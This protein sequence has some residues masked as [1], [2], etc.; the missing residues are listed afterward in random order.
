[1]A[2]APS[3]LS[4]AISGSYRID[5]ELGRGGMAVVFL[6]RDLKHDRNVALKVIRPDVSYP[7]IADRFAREIRLA[8]RLQ[9]PHILPVLDSG[10][11]A[12][13]LWYTM[14]YVEGE[15]L[16]DRL[17]REKQLPIAEAL[18]VTRE[19]AQALE[20]AHQHSVIHRDIKPENILLTKDGSVLVADF[21]IARAIAGP[22]NTT[23]TAGGS[24]Q[25]TETGVS[26]GTP[27]YMSPEQ[28]LGVPADARS[29]IYSLAAVLSELVTGRMVG[30]GGGEGFEHFLKQLSDTAP[31]IRVLR[32]EVSDAVESAV[33]R[34]L[35]PDPMQRFP[36]M[37]AFARALD[38]PG[39]SPPTSSPGVRRAML[40]LVT[41]GV[42][43]SAGLLF[44]A[45]SRGQGESSSAVKTMVVLPFVDVS[46]D[47]AEAYFAQGMADELT[48]TLVQLS[49]VRLAGQSAVARLKP[50]EMNARDAG[51]R[52]NVES[53]LEGTVRR[54]GPRLRVTAQL[55]NAADGI[56]LW[57]ERYDR[58][59]KDVFQVQDEITRAIAT[60][61]RATLGQPLS[62]ATADLEAYDLYL[63]GRYY[64]S[65]RGSEGLNKAIDFFGRAVQS[66]SS[67]ARAHAGLSMAYA[68]LPIFESIDPDSAMMLAE[69]SAAHALALDSSLAEAHLAL[70]YTL[71]NRWRFVEAEREFRAALALAPNDPGVH[72][73]YG[74]LLYAIGRPE[75]SVNELIRAREL[76]PF[77][78][79]IG[80]DAGIA[81]YAARRFDDARRE[82]ERSYQLDSTKSD[83]WLVVAWTQLALGFPDSAIASLERS[84]RFR[85]AFDIRPYL[86]VA[87]RRLGET[88]KADSVAALLRRDYARG[89]AFAF[90]VAI[91]AA[92]AGDRSTAIRAIEQTLE[93]KSLL[94]TEVSL[95][96][97]PLL[98]PIRD[99]PRFERMLATVG[100]QACRPTPPP[101]GTSA[102]RSPG[103]PPG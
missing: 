96:C 33:R 70:A 79:T 60:A 76:D 91:A 45:L 9:H 62:T 54:S 90:D 46:G 52:L 44:K 71:K 53:V 78:S 95:P 10:E 39:G 14:P 93:D 84:Q 19:A 13:Q 75:E 20:Y 36:S 18:R 88:K 97:E 61:L 48:T 94:V 5:R 55:T 59:L 26:L 42:L 89:R 68:V 99:D 82:A 3:T 30:A 102:P 11:A 66:D 15:S 56:V 34:A 100:M 28:R 1:M 7:G 2:D 29:D 23:S 35:H 73:W 87:Y 98:D 86:S 80:T 74:V 63:R 51:R 16:R 47:T 69:L 49:G 92:G 43:V 12:G 38:Q 40:A 50:D 6:A 67:F 64:W 57:A 21:G 58:D 103:S 81:F 77:G 101:A 8:A 37:E 65:K 72:H 85:T 25:L 41:G 83:N 31:G 22:E 27:A 24:T 32:P 4:Q 17:D